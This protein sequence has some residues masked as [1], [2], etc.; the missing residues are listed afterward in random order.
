MRSKYVLGLSG[1][2]DSVVLAYQ[3]LKDKKP[4]RCVVNDFGSANSEREIKTAKYF[5]S[6]ID[7]NLEI[8]DVKGLGNLVSTFGFIGALDGGDTHD[9]DPGGDADIRKEHSSP[10]QLYAPTGYYVNVAVMTFYARLVG[11]E[12]LVLGITKDDIEWRPNLLTYLDKWSEMIP[13]IEESKKNH[14][15]DNKKAP[16]I[17]K[18]ESPFSTL[19]KAQVIDLGVEMD[20]QLDATYSCYNGRTLHCGKC[21]ACVSRKN[22]FTKSKQALDPTWY[23]ELPNIGRLSTWGIEKTIS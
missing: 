5:A 6:I 7:V 22:A 9:P 11:I 21:S 15:T 8:I 2:L 3:L 4:F 20:V 19:S 17:F 23:E 18:I 16:G 10:G 12:T 13:L 14:K 1:G